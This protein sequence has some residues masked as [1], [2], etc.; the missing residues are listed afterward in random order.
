MDQKSVRLVRILFVLVVI[1]ALALAYVTLI[2]PSANAYVV[3][4]QIEAQQILISEIVNQ[5]QTSGYVQ[6]PIGSNQS[7]VLVR[8][9]PSQDGSVS[10]DNTTK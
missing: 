4:K 9:V 6:I 8:Y 2:K 10:A 1:L 3:N 5:V 7:L